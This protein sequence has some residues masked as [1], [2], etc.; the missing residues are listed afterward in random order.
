MTVDDERAARTMLA[1][2]TAG[3]PSAPPDRLGAVRRRAV[4]RRR[5][6]FAA[7][8]AVVA[9][10]AVAA[11]TIPLRLIGS[12]P[13]VAPASY[14][15]SERPPGPGD[16]AGLVAAGV[17]DGKRWGLTITPESGSGPGATTGVCTQYSP[18]SGLSCGEG[19]PQ[20]AS[21]T[22]APAESYSDGRSGD[23]YLD[24]ATVR[25][26]VTSLQVSYTNGQVITLHPV[27]V[28]AGPYARYVVI[29]A[30]SAGS[31]VTVTAFAGRRDL[32]YAVPFST[33][34]ELDLIRWLKPGQPARPR[35]LTRVIGS[36]SAGGS[37]WNVKVAIGPWGTCIYTAA[38]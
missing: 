32:G 4:L 18:G 2:L 33:P 14:H 12:A 15:L 16:H 35:P 5:R 27:A 13:P 19:P 26:D 28:F 1:D 22:G 29:V 23:G 37:S 36:G 34:D 6:Q 17:L 30:P 8:A 10:V 11:A 20:R 21:G 38:A 7:I 31:V 9:I 3:Q 24:V 25:S